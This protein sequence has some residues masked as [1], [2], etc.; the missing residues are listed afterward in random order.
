MAG[1][2]R[3]EGS[4]GCLF[5]WLWRSSIPSNLEDTR[6]YLFQHQMAEP[7]RPPALP[8]SP[9]KPL[10]QITPAASLLR[11]TKSPAN[12]VQLEVERNPHQSL[13]I[14]VEEK[15]SFTSQAWADPCGGGILSSPKAPGAKSY[16]VPRQANGR[17]PEVYV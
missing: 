16:T 8:R 10:L 6:E 13:Q 15:I 5:K 7:P 3:T 1:R 12:L 9:R 4:R 11:V 14:T 2:T 17:F